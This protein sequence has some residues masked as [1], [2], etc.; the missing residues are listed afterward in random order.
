M[1]AKTIIGL[2]L[3]AVGLFWPQIQERIPDFTIPSKPSI[4]IIEPADSILKEKVSSISSEVVDE[5][6]RLN[7]AVFN[8]VFSERVLGYPEIKAQQVNDIYTNSAKIFFGE[9]LKGKYKNLASQ[10]TS[11]MSETLGDE[12]H[13]VSPAELQDLSNNFQAL[14]WSFSK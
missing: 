8:N 2:A 5:M 3:L 12:D 10:L 11:L 6:D 13:V 7:L 1:K 9:K 14:A 4:E